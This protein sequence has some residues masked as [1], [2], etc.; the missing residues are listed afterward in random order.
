MYRTLRS[1]IQT[2]NRNPLAFGYGF[3]YTTSNQTSDY[4]LCEECEGRLSR[5]GENWV[6][7]YC[8]RRRGLFPLGN[9]LQQ[10]PPAYADNDILIYSAAS[11]PEIDS[12][13]ITYF[14]MSVFWRAAAHRWRLG[15]RRIGINLGPYAEPIR[16]YLL[17]QSVFPNSAALCVLVGIE[18]RMIEWAM[19]PVSHNE[20]GFHSHTFTIP[21]MT[22]M[23]NVGGRLP[24][25]FIEGSFAPS[26]QRLIAIFP[27]AERRQLAEIG[28][29]YRS[30]AAKVRGE[31]GRM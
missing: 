19:N 4:L 13:A 11:I 6:L 25:E 16:T 12:A 21:G 5:N 29:A 30:T 17:G 7:R 3:A 31:S 24:S 28:R 26:A 22:F 23:L 10:I 14:G 18:D 15:D 9:T 1:V 27:E 2:Q 8:Y 20:N